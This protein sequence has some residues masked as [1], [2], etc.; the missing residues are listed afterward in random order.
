M[1]VSLA[2]VIE[3]GGYNLSTYTD[4]QWLLSK[5]TEFEELVEAAQELVDKIESENTDDY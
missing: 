2:E 1:S 3:S 5:Q 4:A